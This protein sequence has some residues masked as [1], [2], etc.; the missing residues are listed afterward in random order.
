MRFAEPR[1]P[2]AQ[3]LAPR[4]RPFDNERRPEGFVNEGGQSQAG[5]VPGASSP[6]THRARPG[7]PLPLGPCWGR[8]SYLHS[9][10]RLSQ[11]TVRGRTG[12]GSPTPKTSTTDRP[13]DGVARAAGRR[14]LNF[15]VTPHS[16]WLVRAYGVRP[17]VDLK[18]TLGGGA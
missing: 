17:L 1:R 5:R 7:Q 14:D 9:R 3:V 10:L 16:D 6:A 8:R 13:G 4:N 18:N 11:E 2:T 12:C 15:P